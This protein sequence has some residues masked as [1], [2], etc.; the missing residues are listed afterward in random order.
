LIGEKGAEYVAPNWQLRA[1]PELFGMLE[2][3]RISG[4]LPFASGGFTPSINS[5]NQIGQPM[6]LSGIVDAV[7]AGV[8]SVQIVTTVQDISIAQTKYN[9]IVDGASF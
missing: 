5:I 2:A 7:V 8:Q 6:D 3:N 4:A 1:Y 9:T